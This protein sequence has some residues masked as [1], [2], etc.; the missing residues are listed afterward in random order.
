MWNEQISVKIKDHFGSS[1]NGRTVYAKW[2]QL[3]D[4]EVLSYLHDILVNEPVY[5]K[6]TNIVRLILQNKDLELCP[7]CGKK[8]SYTYM[9][10][11][12]HHCSLKFPFFHFFS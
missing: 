9:I 6:E 7:V 10:R 11:G 1:L 5:E 3:N 12:K 2:K 4:Q 8:I